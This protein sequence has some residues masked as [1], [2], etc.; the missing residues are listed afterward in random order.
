MCLFFII[1]AKAVLAPLADN[2]V[3][4]WNIFWPKLRAVQSIVY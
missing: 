1:R 3:S 4:F 2:F